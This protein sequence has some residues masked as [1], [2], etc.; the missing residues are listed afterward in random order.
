M[1]SEPTNK[2]TLSFLNI[3]NLW[4][5]PRGSSLLSRDPPSNV[6]NSQAQRI[7][8]VQE[9]SEERNPSFSNGVNEIFAGYGNG[10]DEMNNLPVDEFDMEE[11][12][13]RDEL[14][15]NDDDD[16]GNERNS[17]RIERH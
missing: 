9:R 7:D 10:S 17:L 15:S 16:S 11:S 14:S 5:N 3:R 1:G 6:P 13:Q 8:Q 4:N 2:N 12:L